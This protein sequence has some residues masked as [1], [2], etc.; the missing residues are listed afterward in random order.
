MAQVERWQRPVSFTLNVPPEISESGAVG[1]AARVSR[2]LAMSVPAVKRGR[3]LIAG[4]LGTLR[5]KKHDSGRRVVPSELLEQPEEDIARSVTMTATVD[6][7]LFEGRSWWR[8]TAF[9]PDGFPSKVRRLDP[10]SVTVRRNGR[11][12][13]SPSGQAQGM[14]QEWVPDEQLIR[15]DSP[16]DPLL[17]AAA[18]A[19]RAAHRLERAAARYADEPLPLGYFTPADGVDPGDKEL[20]EQILDDWEDARER[21]VW[22]YVGAGLEPHALQWSPEQLQLSA[23]RDYAVLEIARAIGVDPEELGVSTTSR[24]YANAEQRRLDLVD[25]T[26]AAYVVAIEDRLSMPDVTPPGYYVRA[27]YAGFLRSDTLTRMQTY[28]IGRRVGVYNDERIAEIEDIPSARPSSPPTNSAAVASPPAEVGDPSAAA[29]ASRRPADEPAPADRPAPQWPPLEVKLPNPTFNFA[30]EDRGDLTV[31]FAELP[32]GAPAFKVDAPSRRITGTVIPWNTVAYSRGHRWMFKPGSLHWAAE[33]RVKLDRDHEYGSEFG[34]AVALRND[35]RAL[36]GEFAVA[37]GA[38]GDRM[39]A[40][41]EDGVYDGLS[42]SVTFEADADGWTPHP[43]DPSLRV[44]HSATLRKVAL[45]AMP[46]FDDAR[47]DSVAARREESRPEKGSTMTHEAA[48]AAQTSPPA[49]PAATDFAAL[50][51][52]I[53]DA[54]RKSVEE[55]FAR[56]PQPQDRQVVPAGRAVVTREAPVYLMNGHGPSLVRDSWKARTEGD[57]EAAERLR[58]F[59]RQTQD[60]AQAAMHPDF[61]I[62]TSSASQIIPPGYRP[63]LYVTQLMQGRPLVDAVSR[64]T[65]S[66][67][68]PFNIPAFVSAADATDTHVEGTN[69]SAGT[70]TLGT[71]TV[72]P[73]A[74]SGLFELTREIVDSANPAVDAI[75]MAAMQE[76][77]AQQTEALVYAQLN[78]NTGQGGT[79]SNGL[80]P[81][82]AQVETSAA[83]GPEFIGKIRELLAKYPFR[84]FG[85]PNRAH[86]SAEGTSLLATATGED[87]RPLLPSVGAQNTAGVGNAVQQGWFIDGL[88]FTPTWSMTGNTS[89]DADALIF[90]SADVWAWESPLLMFRFE[91]R[92]GPARIDLALFG[93]FATR[94][95]RPVGIA[96]VRADGS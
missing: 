45:T 13:V 60:A 37:R 35:E 29:E 6:D 56:L 1:G 82:G 92:N 18:G 64:G 26:L 96:A 95:L 68:T 30:A 41:A 91:E 83:D 32:D 57:H 79:P 44:V 16:N 17:T 7:M 73:G 28:E 40:L 4:T 61:A 36:L 74:I 14:A 58:K 85:A 38:D 70:L 87:G 62:T 76:S 55:A 72:T 50:T 75:A 20:I 15:I 48:D 86:V 5:F 47:V 8:I 67:A 25:F 84:R 53:G 81:S 59:S 52:G 33:A 39:L 90:N 42:A 10:R 66:D 49:A 89:G 3:D 19:I 80:V 88:A 51:S 43:D 11:V 78:G 71:V 54:I 31:G 63:D 93:Y 24:T 77:Y 22:G 27:D 9:G 34:R 2:E 46:A 69:P 94:V 65:L 23:A 21:R 12:Y